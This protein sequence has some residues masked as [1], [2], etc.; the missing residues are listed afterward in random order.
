M[1]TPEA[2]VTLFLEHLQHRR[3]VAAWTL[4]EPELQAVLPPVALQDSWSEA[5]TLLGAWQRCAVFS[6]IEV[7]AFIQHIVHCHFERGVYPWQIAVRDELISG[8][9]FE[10]DE[11][12][13]P[14]SR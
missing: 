4:C 1:R 3:F 14:A 5:I 8:V 13:T 12:V 2:C 7:G 6:R 11:P 10:M 9:K